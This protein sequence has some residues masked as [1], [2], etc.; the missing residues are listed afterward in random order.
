[1]T[2]SCLTLSLV[3]LLFAACLAEAAQVFSVLDYGAKADGVTDD[4][5]AFTRAF[6]AAKAAGGGV[7]YAPQGRYLIAGTL[8][9]PPRVV[10][11]GDY[12]GPAGLSGTILLA[13]FGE[14]RSDGPGCIVMHGGN[15]A[16]R[17][18]AIDYPRQRADAEAPIPYPYAIK[19]AAYSS[20]EH[21][22][23]RNPYQG[24][25]LSYAHMDLVRDVSGE[26]LAIGLNADHIHDISRLENIHFWPYFTLGKPLRQWVQDHGVAFQFGCSDWQY[27]FNTFCYGYHTCYRF[28]KSEPE[29][30]GSKAPLTTNGNFVGIGADRCVIG[31]DVEA[32]FAIGV[33]ITNG[34]FAP[35]G[36]SDSRAIWL[37]KGNTGNLT[38][39]NCNFW[40]V[41]DSLAEVEG[42]ALTL[43]ACNI[44]EWAVTHKAAPAFLLSGGRLK[45]E[46]CTFNQGGKLAVLKGETARASF[47]GNMG[48]EPSFLLNAIDER[49]VVS[50]NNPPLTI[51]TTGQDQAQP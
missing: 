11:Q 50:A 12:V 41:P 25:D 35:F 44:H 18:L 9:V 16:V 5:P 28:F 49:L 34:M 33:S 42:G 43:S 21:V 23:L 19:V 40:A 13:T 47:V 8:N 14:G 6:E 2:H 3:V 17:N 46:G 48:T 22:F 29:K 31:V 37:H 10:L 7:V 27:C 15:C 45:V 20:V 1:M 26:P 39:T 24:L 32:A 38:F 30:P 51:K 36:A 4:T